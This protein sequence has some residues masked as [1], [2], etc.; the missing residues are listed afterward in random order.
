M[1]SAT[2]GVGL[3]WSGMR[4]KAGPMAGESPGPPAAS[5]VQVPLDKFLCG[6]QFFRP[7]SPPRAQRREMIRTIAEEYKFNIIRIWPNWDYVNPEP[8]Q[9]IFDEVEEVMNHCDEFGLK[10]LCGLMFELAPWW[11]EE[12]YP[13]ARFTDA[14]GQAVSIGGSPNNV[15]GG[16]P[17]LCFDWEPVREAG[18][19]Y[20][21]E[22]I[23]VVSPHPSLFGYDCWN[24]P[25][26]EPAWARNIWAQP[27][28]ILF[29]YCEKTIE[30]FRAWLKQ[31]YGTLEALNTAWT[32]RYPHWQAL[33]PPR[34]LGTYAD[35]VDW[36]RFIFERSTREMR[37]RV[38]TARAADPRHVMESH[39]AHH[40]PVDGCATPGTD[41]WRLAE[42]LDAW[43]M[44]LFP[45]WQF[46]DIYHGAAKYEITRSNAA[47]KPFYLTELQAGHG[48]EGHWRSP[49]MRPRD[50]RLYNWLAVAMGAKGVIYWNY[51]AEAT[52]REATGYGLVARSGAAT[53]R[54]KEAAKNHALIQAHWDIIRDFHPRAEVA[55][56][57]DLDNALLTYAAQGNEAPSTG[58]FLGYYK[59]L[60]NLDLWVDFVEPAGL[61]K[62]AY[63]VVIAPWHLIGKQHTCEQLRRFVEDGGTLMIETGFGLFDEN[64]YYNPIVPPFGLDQLFGYREREAFWLKDEKA[65]P[66]VPASDRVYYQPSIAF[67]SPFSVRVTGR[68][69]LTPI[70][71]TSAQSI[72]R[73]GDMTVAATKKTG[74]GQV[75]Y[76]GT[77]LGASIKAGSN[78]GIELL[79]AIITRV[80]KSPVAGGKVR[81][82]LIESDKGS[83]LLVFNDTPQDQMV[84]LK[85]P[86]RYRKATDLLSR[87]E[88]PVVNNAVQLTVPYQDVT[89]LLLA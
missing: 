33:D 41:A 69:Y 45:R 3:A 68:T 37:F 12:K 40:P 15:T 77:N 25:H 11:L 64:L 66:D 62:G 17:G 71:V 89:V 20:I 2:A 76:F 72:A 6:S 26:I 70:E 4:I 18:A 16:W 80:V 88:P 43:G 83:L 75:Y 78:G 23:K 73:C 65:P 58:S 7:P 60:W 22:L 32:R 9:W 51:L 49:R 8:D 5:T 74:K 61:E 85:L 29:C 67:T 14:K 48:N 30:A 82:R 56:L 79:R 36:R 81:P 59:A 52:G 39:A 46:P 13:G 42:V 28:E 54:S 24:E 47:G 63:K 27:Q 84:T 53:E 44:S 1:R 50:I 35:W 57:T 55:L 34:Y 86:A 10:V 21:Q 19:K 87:T 31:K 38:E